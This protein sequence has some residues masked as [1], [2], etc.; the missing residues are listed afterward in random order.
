MTRRIYFR[1][2]YLYIVCIIA[3]IIFIVGLIMVYN[4]TV[5]YVRP[6]TYMTKSSIAAMYS[7]EQ[8]PDLSADEID[9]LAEEEIGVSI[10]NAKDMAFKDLLRGVLLVIIAIPLFI[11][12]WKKA[13]VMWSINLE[14]KDID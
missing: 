3:I 4:G 10:R 1:E 11:F 6:A 13:Q 7:T 14:A 9:R 2:I 12:H 5:D 8:Y